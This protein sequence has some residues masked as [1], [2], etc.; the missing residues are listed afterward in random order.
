MS[1]RRSKPSDAASVGERIDAFRAQAIKVRAH[2]LFAS[3]EYTFENP[4]NGA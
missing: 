3:S 4:V 1:S 2:P